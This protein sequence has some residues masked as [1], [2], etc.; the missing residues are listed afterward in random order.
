MRSGHAQLK[1]QELFQR[2]LCTCFG[3]P[4]ACFGEG[5]GLGV[6]GSEQSPE[7]ARPPRGGKRAKKA[8]ARSGKLGGSSSV[9]AAATARGRRDGGDRRP[10]RQPT[11]SLTCRLAAART[12]EALPPSATDARPTRRCGTT[13]CTPPVADMVLASAGARGVAGSHVPRASRARSA[14]VVALAH[15]R[16]VA[17]GAPPSSGQQDAA[18]RE[19]ACALTFSRR[20]L[21]YLEHARAARESATR[22][23]AS[24]LLAGA[25]TAC[26]IAATGARAVR[27]HRSRRG[28]G[29]PRRAARAAR[30]VG[31]R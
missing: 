13:S 12:A 31:S 18:V 11:A 15:G 2:K 8:K 24:A 29:R 4:S 5:G 30:H 19:E 1:R 3:D 21:D 26:A 7:K 9:P 23:D 17:G 6:H 27:A 14:P 16:A 28:R 25:P 10:P 22:R 20:G